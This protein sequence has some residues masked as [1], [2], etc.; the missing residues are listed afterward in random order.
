[1]YKRKLVILIATVSIFLLSGCSEVDVAGERNGADEKVYRIGFITAMTGSEGEFGQ[2]QKAVLD[3]RLDELNAKNNFK[4]E[5]SSEDGECDVSVANAALRKH[6]DQNKLQ[7]VIGGHCSAATFGIASLANEYDVIL[8]SAS[9]FNDDLEGVSPNMMSLSYRESGLVNEISKE[10]LNYNKVA[11]LYEEGG[12]TESLGK[13]LTNLILTSNEEAK[14]LV[15][16]AFPRESTDFGALIQ[17]VRDAKAEVLFLNP[18]S[19]Q[20]AMALLDA[21]QQANLDV[22][23]IGQ[24]TYNNPVIIESAPQSIEGMLVIDNPTATK[25]G[26]AEYK[27]KMQSSV[28]RLDALGDYYTASTLDALDLYA[29]LISENNGDFASVQKALST[30]TFTGNIGRISFNGKTFV[31]GPKLQRKVVKNGELVSQ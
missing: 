26:F 24:F 10:L 3:Y 11:I 21:I 19:E 2:Q 4:M 9:T 27:Q 14:L 12:E 20:S 28:G 1:M 16:S 8:L 5:M 6:I 18:A 22:K 17:K 23:L 7:F 13:N 15:N 31:E 29:K 25:S 30:G